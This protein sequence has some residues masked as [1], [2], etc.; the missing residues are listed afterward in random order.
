[1]THPNEGE[2][3][4]YSFDYHICGSVRRVGVAAVF[5]TCA[6]RIF[7][8]WHVDIRRE[9]IEESGPVPEAAAREEERQL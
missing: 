2:K 6:T 7:L 1:M 3:V 8:E 5:M 4:E 9:L